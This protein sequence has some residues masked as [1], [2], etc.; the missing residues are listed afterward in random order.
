MV[1]DV[2]RFQRRGV[3]EAAHIPENFKNGARQLYVLYKQQLVD[4]HENSSAK[5]PIRILSI[6]FFEKS[7]SNTG[8][9]QPMRGEI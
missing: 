7:T 6:N 4:T 2:I 9:T 1:I 5:S 3:E 8:S